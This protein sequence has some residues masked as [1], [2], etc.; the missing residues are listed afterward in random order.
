ME[1]PSPD[2][3]EAAGAAVDVRGERGSIQDLP[4]RTE[5]GPASAN[6]SDLPFVSVVIP[7]WADQERLESCLEALKGQDYP[8]E[9]MEVI[10]VDNGSGDEPARL[11]A[12]FPQIRFVEEGTPG[13]YKARNRGIQLARGEILAFTDSD[14]I[15]AADWIASGVRRLCEM[16][17]IGFLA[18]SVVVAPRVT[19]DPSLAELYE[20]VLA[21]PQAEYVRQA[22]FGATCNLFT[23]A[24]VFREVG[25]FDDRLYSAGDIE[26]GRRVFASGRQMV[27]A[28]DVRVTHRARASVAEL[29]QRAR[30][31][32][33][34]ALLL[35]QDRPARVLSDQLLFLFPRPRLVWKILTSRQTDD[36]WKRA[37]L[38]GLHLMLRQVKFWER[39]RI[40][41][42]G[43]P[44]R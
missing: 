21:F 31:V 37:L 13:S 24:G 11:G 1:T 40:M 41:L 20:I 19:A 16:S 28:Q 8:A 39:V 2:G 29:I 38:L 36:P 18:G 6:G 4:D 42:G 9:R 12:R 14:C 44:L 32:A 3:N 30:R 10:V 35:E 7:V 23:T 5:S 22:H 27:Y 26:W 15:P 17:R 43:Q 33:A 25:V 34:G